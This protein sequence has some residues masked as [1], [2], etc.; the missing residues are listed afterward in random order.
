M[1]DNKVRAQRW[2]RILPL[3]FLMYTIA[4]IDRNNIGFAFA[5]I[6]KDL[7]I[8][9]TYAGLAAGVFFFGYMMLQVPGGHLA[10]KWSAKKFI[11][12]SLFAWGIAATA[13]G[14]VH[15]LPML[16]IVRF[17]V[18][19]T[20]GG[21][22]TAT[23]ILISKWFPL[24]ER[25]RANAIF[26]MCTPFAAIIMSPLSGYLLDAFGWRGM[27]IIEGLLPFVFLPFWLWLLAEKPSEAKWISKEER[28]Y[29]ETTF[30]EEKQ[31]DKK[32]VNAGFREV[33]KSKSF[34]ILVSFYFLIQM[35]F[36]GFSLWLPTITQQ[37][38]GGSNT[39]VGFLTALPW[40]A[41]VVGLILFPRYSDKHEKRKGP[42]ALSVGGG[43][44]FLLISTLLDNVSPTLS[45]I[46]LIVCMGFLLGYLGI[47]WVIPNKIIPDKLLGASLGIINIAGAL[48]GFLGPFLVGYITSLTGSAISGMFLLVAALFIAT[49]L[50]LLVKEE[51]QQVKSQDTA[52][53]YDVVKER[54]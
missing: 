24:K 36:Y 40:I 4:N 7:G 19:V 49:F 30:A 14:F 12:L 53:N 52:T 25:A 32:G 9:A 10:N 47:F 13:M 3:L 22:W 46:S 5:G 43:A 16:L 39:L 38:S 42:V 21:V 41:S 8:G 1:S 48:G 50:I 11:A 37:L 35:G 44:I 23:L 31:Q 6:E 17:L 51:K 45:F 18:G 33:F 2:W 29:L 15:N 34:W 54:V 26:I 28:D 27:F 20:E